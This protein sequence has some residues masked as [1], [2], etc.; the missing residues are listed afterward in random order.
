MAE[1]NK[2]PVHE[3]WGL[4]RFSVVGKLLSAPPPWGEL[5]AELDRLAACNWIHPVT[6]DRTHFAAPTIERWL[7]EARKARLDPVAALRTKVRKDA[8][9]QDTMGPHLRKAL[10]AQHAA[11]RSWSAQLH[12]DNLVALAETKPEIGPVP[13]YSTIRRFL[14]AQ[15]LFRRRRVT[16]RRTAGA[17]IAEARLEER[18]VRS[19]EA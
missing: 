2:P 18:E 16:S 19:Y 9:H 4:L 11:H 6:G 8:G 14:K 15:G 13:S 1:R 5:Q 12:V 10:R 3:R 17:E 7:R